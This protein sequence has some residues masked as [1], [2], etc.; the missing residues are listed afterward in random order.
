MRG[1]WRGRQAASEGDV[2]ARSTPQEN[3]KLLY[4]HN[5]TNNA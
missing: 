1:S 2:T 4:T 3:K 5:P